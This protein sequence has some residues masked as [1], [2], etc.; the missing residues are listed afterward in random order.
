MSVYTL[1]DQ[2]TDF[3]DLE[4]KV[5]ENSDS[6]EDIN[7]EIRKDTEETK[8]VA[9]DAEAGDL[10]GKSVSIDGDYCI[11]GAHYD[12]DGGSYAGAAYIFHKTGTD[13]WDAGIKIVA[14]DAEADDA[15]GWEVSISGDYAIVGAYGEDTGGSNAGAAYIFHRTGTNTWDTGTKIVASDA[16]ASDAFG[17][18]VSIDGDY[19]IVGTH[20]DDDGGSNA[21]AAYIFHRTG[22][23]TWDTGTKIVASD[24]EADDRFGVSVSISG[25]YAIVGADGES[26]GGSGAGAAYIFHRTGLNTW[27]T[28]TKIV[29]PDAEAGDAFG[30]SV[31]IDG[32]YCVVSATGEGISGSAYIFHRT[33]TNTWDTGT[34]IVSSDIQTN[35]WFGRSVSICGDYCIVG[36]SGEDTGASSAG[37]AYVFHR[38]GTNSWDA[39]TKITP[40][41]PATDSYFGAS[42][43]ISERYYISGTRNDDDEG[44]NA[45]AAY[46]YNFNEPIDLQELDNTIT[47][48]STTVEEQKD[49]TLLYVSDTEVKIFASDAGADDYFGWSVSID[50]D[51]CIVGAYGEDTGGTMAGAAY[52]FHR[53]GDNIWDAGTKIMSSDI[54]AGD[55]FGRSVSID[56]DYCIVGAYTEATGGTDAGAAYIFHR[57]GLNTWDAGT[58]I[59]AS[60]AETYDYFGGSVSI[61]GDYCIVGAIGETSNTG[62]A[63]IFHRTG[64]N[65]WDTG[66]KIVASDV[67]SGD[68][69]GYS[70]SISGDYCVAGSP[71]KTVSG[72]SNSGAASIFHR[73]GTNTWD[74]GTNFVSPVPATDITF[75]RSVSI[76][77]DYA[78]IDPAPPML[79]AIYFYHRTGTNTWEIGEKITSPN[80][81]MGDY[82]GRSLT[83]D[84]EYAIIGSLNESSSYI[85][86]RAGTNT[87]N[88]KTEIL[89]SGVTSVS[90]SGKYCV[91]GDTDNDTVASNAGAAYIYKLLT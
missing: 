67:A 48:N 55:F 18:E 3:L 56:G 64:T 28:G 77:G 23:N 10:F 50:G 76:S 70:V 79:G 90:I 61:D 68:K 54:E 2:G 12:D 47:A 16:E 62:A 7:D 66:T 24:A 27:D 57:T 4:T 59:V 78:V 83:I 53:T 74:T 20:Y 35:D 17:Y 81:Y 60:D 9:P 41:D 42:V 39:G 37:A 36:A 38:T 34:K 88:V 51:Y 63:Y 87:W 85:Y 26:T 6:I 5:S 75:G 19:C 84:G 8:I 46:I 89:S 29:A 86:N 65:T 49:F 40:S 21:G 58:K 71:D 30:K 25:D 45:G 43:S 15:F 73:T 82:F 1:I 32:D 69:F 52:I 31:S 91:V 33:G 22:I 72:F 13:T 14:S 11:V 44:S 80:G